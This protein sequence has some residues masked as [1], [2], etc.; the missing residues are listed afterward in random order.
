[1]S[2]APVCSNMRFAIVCF[3]LGLVACSSSDDVLIP[4]P[5]TGEDSPPASAGPSPGGEEE[6]TPPT[7]TPIDPQPGTDAGSD[8]STKAPKN[9]AQGKS[10]GCA[11]TT[12]ATGLQTRTKT[13]AGK[14]RDYLRF[15]PAG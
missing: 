10:A 4:A 1:M 9:Y 12:G 11:K 7:P 3:V 14:T 13:I 5:G 15:I 2:R 8:A 6:T